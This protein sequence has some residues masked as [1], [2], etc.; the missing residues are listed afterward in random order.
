MRGYGSTKSNG[1]QANIG[2]AKKK[3]TVGRKEGRKGTKRTGTETETQ[4][5]KATS[6]NASVLLTSNKGDWNAATR[7]FTVSAVATSSLSFLD[8]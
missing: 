5:R 2:R 1:D 4:G 6:S 3:N 7:R 8:G